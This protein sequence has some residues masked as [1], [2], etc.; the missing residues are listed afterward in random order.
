MEK[1]E[2]KTSVNENIIGKIELSPT[3][4]QR[5]TKFNFP[6]EK[7]EKITVKQRTT[8]F[9][10]L[11]HYCLFAGRDDWV[12]LFTNDNGVWIKCMIDLI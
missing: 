11:H 3:V 10:N 6:V 5:T 1:D 12:G 8:K 2:L 9:M 4:K 7:N